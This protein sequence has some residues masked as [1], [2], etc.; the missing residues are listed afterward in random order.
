MR[1]KKRKRGGKVGWLLEWELGHVKIGPAGE[2]KKEKEGGGPWAE[3]G[4]E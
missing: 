3:R 4:R 1:M 2:E